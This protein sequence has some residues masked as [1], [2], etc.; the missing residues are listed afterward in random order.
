MHAAARVG[1]KALTCIGGKY[2]FNLAIHIGLDCLVQSYVRL[3][4]SCIIFKSEGSNFDASVR[5]GVH[6]DRKIRHHEFPP[7]Y[8]PRVDGVQG[9][10]SARANLELHA[11]VVR[12]YQWEQKFGAALD[13]LGLPART[14]GARKRRS[15][16]K[17]LKEKN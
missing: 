3:A 9:A 12:L 6:R 17:S 10:S 11:H 16:M 15:G 7:M 4:D 2:T 13:S 5:V 14:G 1:K 8:L